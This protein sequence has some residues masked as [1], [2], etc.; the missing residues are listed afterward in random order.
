MVTN[1]GT[2]FAPRTLYTLQESGARRRG[3]APGA[4]GGA[5]AEAAEAEEGEGVSV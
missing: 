1:V 5:G 4:Q 3:G 2:G